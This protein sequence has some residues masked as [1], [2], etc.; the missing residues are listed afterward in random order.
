M[1]DTNTNPELSFEVALTEL[2]RIL[3]SLEDGTATLDD[4]L[5]KYERGVSLLRQCY[6]QLQAAEHKIQQLTGTDEAGRPVL[7]PFDHSSTASKAESGSAPAPKRKKK[8][9]DPPF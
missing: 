3:K 5:A 7:V 6:G 1:P 4:S 8:E 2:D 9:N